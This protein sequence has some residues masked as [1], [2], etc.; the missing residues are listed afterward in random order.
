MSGVLKKYFKTVLRNLIDSAVP[1]SIFDQFLQ[2]SR[3]DFKATSTDPKSS[4][5]LSDEDRAKLLSELTPTESTFA[6]P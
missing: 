1:Q 3:C 6:W 5:S 4:I 2:V